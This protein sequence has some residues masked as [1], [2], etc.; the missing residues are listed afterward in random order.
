MF[1]NLFLFGPKIRKNVC[2][3]FPFFPAV[4]PPPPHTHTHTL[5]PVKM[6]Y[7]LRMGLFLF[8]FHVCLSSKMHVHTFCSIGRHE[9]FVKFCLSFSFWSGDFNG[10]NKKGCKDQEPIQSSTTPDPGYQWE[11][12]KL[13]VRHHKREP[14]GQPFPSR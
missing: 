10:E 1:V 4:L 7:C 8:I 3:P 14:R 5:T 6:L 2:L 13:T 11:R 12:D 9:K